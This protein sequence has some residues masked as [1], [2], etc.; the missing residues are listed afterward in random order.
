MYMHCVL[1]CT[2]SGVQ[3]SRTGVWGKQKRIISI[4]AEAHI[5]ICDP[6]GALL[7]LLLFSFLI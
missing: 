5:V 7:L 2:C 3:T 6:G 4:T 1:P